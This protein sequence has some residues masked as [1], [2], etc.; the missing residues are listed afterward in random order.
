MLTWVTLA[1]PLISGELHWEREA[2]FVAGAHI[3]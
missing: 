3:R 2:V 1:V